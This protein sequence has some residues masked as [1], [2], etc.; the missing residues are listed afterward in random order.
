MLSRG[1]VIP[2]EDRVELSRA[3]SDR[4]LRWAAVSFAIGFSAHGLDHLRRGITASPTRVMIVGPVQA[5]FVVI[6]VRMTLM[7][8][9][10][11]PV[12]VILVGFGSALL[13][14][15]GHLLPR[16]SADS[17]V[18]APHPSVTWLSWLTAVAEIGTGMIFGVAGVRARLTRDRDL[19]SVS[20]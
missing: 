12:A 14:T 13:F 6:A 10:R 15:Y 1:E 20:Q 18:S 5:V 8:R 16:L 19:L 9:R 2:M 3:Y 11:A 4:F 17:F 7:G